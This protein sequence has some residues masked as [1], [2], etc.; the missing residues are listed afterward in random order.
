MQRRD[1]LKLLGIAPVSLPAFVKQI[2]K[3]HEKPMTA[4]EVLQRQNEA[5]SKFPD[6]SKYF[7]WQCGKTRFAWEKLR[8]GKYRQYLI[9]SRPKPESPP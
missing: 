5:Y 7:G 9:H 3:H 2:A 4:T 1:F 6:P 8:T